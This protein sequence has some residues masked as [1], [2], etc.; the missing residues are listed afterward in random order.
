MN[1]SL[2]QPTL[3]STGHLLSLTDV[4]T[5]HLEHEHI[6]HSIISVFHWN[7]T[8]TDGHQD[9]QGIYNIDTPP[10]GSCLR[11]TEHLSH[12]DRR[13]RIVLSLRLKYF[14][15]EARTPSHGTSTLADAAQ[16]ERFIYV[17]DLP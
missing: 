13:Y 4:R 9:W 3:S 11:S 14:T 2:Y 7:S 6:T 10:S 5:R 16:T 12:R 8:L 1:N 15:L 17:N